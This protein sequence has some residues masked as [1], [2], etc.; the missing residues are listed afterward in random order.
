MKGIKYVDRPPTEITANGTK[1][2]RNKEGKL[3]REGDQPALINA[4]RT[5]IWYQNDK[6]H[7]EGDQP[8]WIDT[9]GTQEWWQNGEQHR[10][11]DQPAW[12]DA[13]GAQ[14]WWQNGEP[15]REGDQPAYINADGT[16]AWYQHGK[17]HREGDKPAIK[18]ADGTQSWYKNGTKITQQQAK[19]YTNIKKFHHKVKRLAPANIKNW[20]AL[21]LLTKT[22]VFCEWYYAPENVGGKMAKAR[23]CHHLE[24][25]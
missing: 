21:Y 13:D 8:A 14:E 19:A 20:Y 1:I 18:Y 7:R 3:H 11:G 5:Q 4:N 16:Q 6:I 23:I 22:R 2:W 15:H 10:E 12:I 24:T 25:I 9:N 17:R